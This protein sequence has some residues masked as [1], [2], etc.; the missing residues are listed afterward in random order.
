[1]SGKRQRWSVKDM[2]MER[3]IKSKYSTIAKWTP[4]MQWLN[5]VIYSFLRQQYELRGLGRAIRPSI[6]VFHLYLKSDHFSRNIFKWEGREKSLYLMALT[7]R[8]WSLGF[9]HHFVLMAHCQD[10]STLCIPLTRG[11]GNGGEQLHD[12]GF[13]HKIKRQIVDTEEYVCHKHHRKC[14]LKG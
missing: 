6:Y 1:M 8:R 4:K 10:L 12:K 3:I 14:D 2:F 11:N 5:K 7:Y 9:R 13:T